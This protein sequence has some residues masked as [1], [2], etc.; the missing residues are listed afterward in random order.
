MLVGASG[1]LFYRHPKQVLM[2]GTHYKQHWDIPGGVIDEGEM[3]IEAAVRECKEELGIY[4]IP[5]RLLTQ[6]TVRLANGNVL[7]AWIFKGD[8]E[9]TEGFVPDGQEV[10]EAAWLGSTDRIAK[11]QTAPILSQRIRDAIYALYNDTVIYSE[12][13]AMHSSI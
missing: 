8:P 4:A 10:I 12:V 9:A 1:I 2:V 11:T 13:D 5:G 7:V 6:S 3:P